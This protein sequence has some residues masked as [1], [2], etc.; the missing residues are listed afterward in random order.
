MKNAMIIIAHGSRSNDFVI[1][2]NKIVN[3]IK[4]LNNDFN[5]IKSA[6][7]EINKPTLEEVVLELANQDV[8]NI[9]IVPYFLFK[10]I[11]LKK[12]ISNKISKLE[13]L[14]KE[15]EFKFAEPLGFDETI[16]NLLLKRAKEVLEE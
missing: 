7:M 15:I 6:S 5:F 13:E 1:T 16:V 14:Y 12:D 9:V 11:H 8:K 2:F 10:G 3:S 4:Q